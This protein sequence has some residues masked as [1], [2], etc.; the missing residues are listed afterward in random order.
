VCPSR[1]DGFGQV[2]G[3]TIEL[4]HPTLRKSAKDGAPERLGLLKR[5]PVRKGGAPGRTIYL[6]ALIP[7]NW[8]T[9]MRLY[10]S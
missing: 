3:M 1:V 2:R 10:F 9:S 8:S 5:M 7:K 6:N 4:V